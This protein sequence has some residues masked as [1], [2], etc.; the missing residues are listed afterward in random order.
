M[1]P[2][3]TQDGISVGSPTSM[4]EQQHT[5]GIMASIAACTSASVTSQHYCNA[6]TTAVSA[7]VD[8]GRSMAAL[9]AQY[10][11]LPYS[12]A[13]LPTAA[14]SF[15]PTTAAAINSGTIMSMFPGAAG[16]YSATT[17]PPRKNRRER[18]TFTRTQL[19]ILENHFTNSNYP[20]V[21]LREKIANQVQLA[22]SR[23]QVWFKNRRAKQRM[24]DKQKPKAVTVAS[25]IKAEK[26]KLAANRS[27]S[28]GSA[29]SMH[30]HSSNANH[31]NGTAQN[32]LDN[33]ALNVHD[34]LANNGSSMNSEP[35]TGTPLKEECLMSNSAAL[36]AASKLLKAESPI[37]IKHSPTDKSSNLD[38]GLDSSKDTSA[39]S[40]SILGGLSSMNVAGSM[41]AYNG[42]MLPGTMRG[43]PNGTTSGLS[44]FSWNSGDASTFAGSAAVGSTVNPF[45]FSAN[46]SGL[47]STTFNN[48][49][50]PTPTYYPM[51]PLD[52]SFG[53]H[54][55]PSAAAYGVAPVLQPAGGSA[56]SPLGLTV[57]SY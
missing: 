54:S 8:Y 29:R 52:P 6:T 27:T 40:S 12:A 26:N 42:L 57:L 46:Q 51:P 21:Y 1:P 38:S 13:A 50:Y 17:I 2:T 47:S 4:A 15:Y 56:A 34:P 37:D 14:S 55:Y 3:T 18:T 32:S 28:G 5:N 22:E 44:D 16:N 49:F 9:S 41:T 43:S 45:A 36:L 11:L 19:E 10:G 23:I 35:E 25:T 7:A 53:Y 31:H 39:S 24:Q 48:Y 30:Q 20:D 33:S